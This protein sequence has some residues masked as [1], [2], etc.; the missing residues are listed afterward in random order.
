MSDLCVL[1]L[2]YDRLQY[3][4]RTLNTA[5]QSIMW[6]GQYHLHIADDGSPRGYIESLIEETYK[7]PNIEGITVSDSRRSGYGANYNLATQHIHPLYKYVLVLEDDWELTQ[8]L[9][10]RALVRDF[11]EG[12]GCIRLGYLG[13]TQPLKGRVLRRPSGMYLIL[14]PDS[15]EPHVFAGHPRLETVEWQ[16]SV[17]VWP[18]DLDPNS[19]EMAVAHIPNARIGVAWPMDLVRTYG[20]VFAHI[21]TERAR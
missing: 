1:L 15:E 18:T 20:N 4:R 6:A 3:A 10:V 16:R 14:D 8:T 5:L 21:G 11:C 9:D 13:Y 2:T 19:T 7:Y 17:G 12:I